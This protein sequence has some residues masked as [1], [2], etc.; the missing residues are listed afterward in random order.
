MEDATGNVKEKCGGIESR[1]EEARDS[2]H[3][4]GNPI[5]CQSSSQSW[6][7]A[8]NV[9]FNCVVSQK[10]QK[11]HNIRVTTSQENNGFSRHKNKRYINEQKSQGKFT[12]Y[13]HLKSPLQ[14]CLTR[15]AD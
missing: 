14:H 3:T 15:G 6:D 10:E 12:K 5:I 7:P 2:G 11:N 1:A 8:L 13:A 9:Y 4:K